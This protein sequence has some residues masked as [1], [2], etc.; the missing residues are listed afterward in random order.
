MKEGMWWVKCN[1]SRFR[2][3]VN[4]DFVVGVN[5]DGECFFYIDF[6]DM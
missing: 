6:M 5:Y 4:Y 1:Y 3:V 2:L